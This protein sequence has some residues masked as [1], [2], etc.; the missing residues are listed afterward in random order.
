MVERAN[1]RPDGL[2]KLV[3]CDVS[4][5]GIDT[6]RG[7]GLGCDFKNIGHV[8]ERATGLL[9]DCFFQFRATHKS[10]AFHGL[11]DRRTFALSQCPIHLPFFLADLDVAKKVQDPAESK[12]LA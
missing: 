6:E 1:G 2:D 3:A 10:F 9:T 4:P 5:Y 7:L 8:T 12:E 11:V